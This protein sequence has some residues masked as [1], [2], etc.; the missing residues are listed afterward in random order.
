MTFIKKEQVK[1][2]RGYE[3]FY[4]SPIL[5]SSFIKFG[6]GHVPTVVPDPNIVYQFK[7]SVISFEQNQLLSFLGA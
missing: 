7:S 2:A 5:S 6:L 3:K 1:L 4:V